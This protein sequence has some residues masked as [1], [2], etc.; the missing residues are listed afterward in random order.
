[1]NTCPKCN[2]EEIRKDGVVKS[3]QR[4]KCKTCNFHFTVAN[5]GKP[6]S[7]K[8]IALLLY[9]LGFNY[10]QTGNYL[11][12]SHVTVYQ[13]IKQFGKSIIALKREKPLKVSLKELS[14]HLNS[15]AKKDGKIYIS[16]SLSNGELEVTYSEN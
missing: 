13:W 4:F 2:S 5:I 15:S 14:E 6:M 8:V 16:I 3:K 12:I 9:L 10:R 7:L 11:N 1:M